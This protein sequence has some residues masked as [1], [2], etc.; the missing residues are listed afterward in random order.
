[1]RKEKEKLVLGSSVVFAFPLKKSSP[2][3]ILGKVG[4]LRMQKVRKGLTPKIL[5][6]QSFQP[7]QSRCAIQ[8]PHLGEADV[9]VFLQKKGGVFAP[10]FV[11][12][13]IKQL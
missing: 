9:S 4:F 3:P 7:L 6:T 12:N 5:K 2:Y 10:P 11:L 8:L 1:L 13:H